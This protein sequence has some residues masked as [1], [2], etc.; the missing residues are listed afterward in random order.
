MSFVNVAFSPAV[1]K[2]N[3]A[4]LDAFEAQIVARCLYFNSQK[5]KGQKINVP[6]CRNNNK[7]EKTDFALER[8]R[9]TNFNVGA[10]IDSAVNEK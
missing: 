2:I 3:I 5:T 8:S 6:R 7:N 9:G 4:L 1:S 10:Q